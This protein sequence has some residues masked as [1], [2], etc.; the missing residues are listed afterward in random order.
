M[1]DPQYLEEAQHIGL[2]TN[3]L[4]AQGYRRPHSRQIKETPQAVVDRLR[5]L[6]AV[7]G[8]K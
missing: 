4:G 6:L 7:A 5:H 8:A 3:W 2:D 1:K